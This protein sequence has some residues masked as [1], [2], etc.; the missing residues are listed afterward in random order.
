MSSTERRALL[1]LLSL[2]LAGP[3]R[4]LVGHPAGRGARVRSSCSP[5][6]HPSLRWPTGTASSHW[7]ARSGPD[8]RID[9][10]QATPGSSPGCRAWVWRLPR[11]SSRIARAGGHSA[12]PRGSTGCP[13]SAPGCWP[14]SA[15]TWSSRRGGGERGSAG[16]I[17]ALARGAQLARP[18][19]GAS[20]G[21]PACPGRAPRAVNLN[22]ASVSE[23]D[24]LPGIGPARAAAIL[25]EREARGP[26]T[27]VEELS[28]VPGLGPSAIARLRDRVVAR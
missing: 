20:S 13:E 2:G 9:A 18:R 16:S 21:R 1:L 22:S 27:S 7:P 12:A 28:R 4:P 14:P 3:G 11:P 24:G 6:C 26:F 23:L 17:R 19:A 8:E 15:R 5:P 25:Q 10:D